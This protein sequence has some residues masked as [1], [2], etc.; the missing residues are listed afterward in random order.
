MGA[1]K[2]ERKVCRKCHHEN[3]ETA[4]FC[5]ECGAQLEEGE[6]KR[7]SFLEHGFA[8]DPNAN[9]QLSRGFNPS[10][11]VD[12][13]SLEKTMVEDSGGGQHRTVDTR[14]EMKEDGNWYC[15]DCGERNT[16]GHMSC[17]GC[18]RYL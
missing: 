12:S 17:K 13:V 11:V 7:R 5:T 15:P 6:K 2:M 18:G 14:V 9:M 16:A 10:A 3:Q 1:D 8:P 4:H